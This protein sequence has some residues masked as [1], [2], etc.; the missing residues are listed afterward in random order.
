MKTTKPDSCLLQ[1]PVT[2]APEQIFIS[3]DNK[4]ADGELNPVLVDTIECS[5]F[6]GKM[7]KWST[8]P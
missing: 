5:D 4:T 1:I 8:L 7:S 3:V 2:N 6:S